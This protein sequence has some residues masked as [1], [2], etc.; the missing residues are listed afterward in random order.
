MIDYQLHREKNNNFFSLS[1]LENCYDAQT[2]N[3]NTE[4]NFFNR[5]QLASLEIKDGSNLTRNC[6]RN[7]SKVLSK[8]YRP[9]QKEKSCKDIEI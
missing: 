3:I 4:K 5:V 1:H 8:A 2:L 9:F 6:Y 7:K